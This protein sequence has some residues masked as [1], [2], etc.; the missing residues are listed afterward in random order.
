MKHHDKQS[1]TCL[2]SI[3]CS[4]LRVSKLLR[5]VWSRPITTWCVGYKRGLRTA[6]PPLSRGGETAEE[7]TSGEAQR[8]EESRCVG[9]IPTAW[10]GLLSHSGSEQQA[11]TGQLGDAVHVEMFL[12]DHVTYNSVSRTSR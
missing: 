11:E 7:E 3:S 2:R 4:M 1:S 9:P 10:F 6:T 5:K 8:E 12:Q